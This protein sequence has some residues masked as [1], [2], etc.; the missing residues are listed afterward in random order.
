MAKINLDKYYTP[1]TLANYVFKKTKEVIGDENITEYLEPSAGSGV[2]L[3]FLDKPYLAYDIEPE[4]KDIVKQDFLSLEL[5]Y[6]KGRCIIGNP[7]YGDRNTLSVR[8]YKKSIH[9]G[10]YIA[11]LLPASQFNNNNQMYEFDLIHSELVDNREFTDLDKRV[12]LTFNIYKR[13]QKGFNKKPNYKLKNVSIKEA[14]KGQNNSVTD[15]YDIGICSFG[16][17]VGKETE[18]IGQ[19]SNEFYLYI[20]EPFKDR[21][22]ELIRNANWRKI[23]KMTSIEKINQWQVYKYIKDSIPEIN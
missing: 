7:P 14:R 22:V 16:W 18:Y 2:F 20:D 5:D 13:N 9:L 3:D 17:S 8:F 4:H 12:N 21:V 19:Y 6:K 11:F 10:D 1:K 15:D 23:V